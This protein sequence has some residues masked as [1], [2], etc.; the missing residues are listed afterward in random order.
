MSEPSLV[1]QHSR[2]G[3]RRIRL[4]VGAVLVLIISALI[5]LEGR[6]PRAILESRLSNAL[7]G[8]LRIGSLSWRGLGQVRLE[9]ASLQVTG[10]PEGAHEVA[11]VKTADISFSPW[12]L[13]FGALRLREVRV[14][15]V[16]L[17]IVENTQ[18]SGR[19]NLQSLRHL[20]GWDAPTASAPQPIRVE[21]IEVTNAVLRMSALEGGEV[22][23]LGELPLSASV[24]EGADGRTTIAVSSPG[25]PARVDGWLDQ[26]N[27]GFDIRLHDLEWERGF[28]RLLPAASRAMIRQLD[29]VG[30]IPLAQISWSKGTSISARIELQNVEVT[31]PDVGLGDE[32]VRFERAQLREA[33]GAPRVRI[34]SALATINGAKAQVERLVGEFGS[35]STDGSVVPLPIVAELSVDFTAADPTLFAWETRNAWLERALLISPLELH[36]RIPKFESLPDGRAAAIELP[37]AAGN[38]L[39]GFGIVDWSIEFDASATRGTPL[40]LADGSLGPSPVI[41][42]ATMIINRGAGTLS[43]F[44]YPLRQIQAHLKFAGDDAH[45]EY[46]RGLGSDDANILIVGEVGNL[47]AAPSVDLTISSDDAPVDD[48]LIKAL[49]A[50]TRVIFDTV[51]DRAAAAR[52]HDAGLT[53]NGDEVT[54]ATAR[55]VD[56]MRTIESAS[57]DP[58]SNPA[59]IATLAQECGRNRRIVDEGAFE[60]GGRGGFTLNVRRPPIDDAE[61]VVSG[62][63]DIHSASVLLQPFPL[64]LRVTEG[65]IV[66]GEDAVEF[67]PPGLRISTLD[68]GSGTVWGRI[69]TPRREKGR[70]FLPEIGFQVEGVRIDERLEHAI[71]PDDKN[72][73]AGWPGTELSR[74]GLILRQFGVHGSGDC[75]GRVFANSNEEV[76]FAVDCELSGARVSPHPEVLQP[77]G[78]TALFWPEGFTLAD[79]L[80]NIS[81][82]SQGVHLTSFDGRRRDGT[83]HAEADHEFARRSWLLRAEFHNLEL[84]EY[85][86]NLAPH[87]GRAAADALWKRWN[88]RGSFAAHLTCDGIGEDILTRMEI[89]PHQVDFRFP[90]GAVSLVPTGGRIVI[91]N[92]RVLADGF[93]CDLSCDGGPFTS[94]LCLEGAYGLSSDSLQMLGTIA[95]GRLESPA[96]RET[97]VQLG[98]LDAVELYDQFEPQGSFDASFSSSSGA[99]SQFYLQASPH[100]LQLGEGENQFD[101]VFAPH[102]RLE[103][104]NDLITLRDLN[105]SILGGSFS[106]DGWLSTETA[107][108]SLDILMSMNTIGPFSALLGAT[109]D[110]VELALASVKL[111]WSDQ[112]SIPMLRVSSAGG[113]SPLNVAGEVSILGGSL[114]PGFALSD[115][116]AEGSFAAQVT[117][118]S[119]SLV[120]NLQACSISARGLPMTDVTC[121]ITKPLGVGELQVEIPEA[122]LGSGRI[123]CFAAISL[124]SP[125]VYAA[126]ISISEV[127][128]GLCLPGFSGDTADSGTV[129]G[130]IFLDRL[131]QTDGTPVREGRGQIVIHDAELARSSFLLGFAQISQLTLPLGGSLDSGEFDFSIHDDIL[132]FDT[133]NLSSNSLRVMGDG[134][135][136]LTSGEFAMRLRARGTVPILSDFVGTLSDA[137]YKLDLSGTLQSPTV[138]LAPLPD[139]TAPPTLPDISIESKAGS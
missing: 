104:H 114:E 28:I 94:S 67:P 57:L 24:K 58:Q 12:R 59:Q 33:R 49:P 27:M 84:E 68:G 107:Q 30:R 74:G 79:C 69:D 99:E 97:L 31:L 110:A 43:A 51:F 125:A 11:A 138:R 133:F 82:D 120:M 21:M 36:M 18:E 121:M 122:R 111:Q 128:L 10:W 29:P 23:L 4:L 87:P 136:S 96:M 112:L 132:H 25:R 46:L 2:R 48:A 101:A 60:V 75:Q 19:L 1:K 55:V 17:N 66:I 5:V 86:I 32:W 124:D 6:I 123:C 64:P 34:T 44:P 53:F 41:T 9:D 129:D 115:L 77:L 109:P 78:A 20:E 89:T 3:K 52:L 91:E 116:A 127:P 106:A 65:T 93:A 73:P 102:S 35:T 70:A 61:V 135:M 63:I 108:P 16:K 126:D 103:I 54:A 72:C 98:A 137:I 76:Q 83:I 100:T 85:L 13:L 37:R 40:R 7:G 26:L 47:G 8:D 22:R 62:H 92:D 130:R 38:L 90:T 95:L 42:Q 118:V 15:G 39:R 50:P 81:V 14:D 45:V 88:P 71:P 131:L 56:L 119:S 113:G 117:S 80:I 139:L 105:G 134:D